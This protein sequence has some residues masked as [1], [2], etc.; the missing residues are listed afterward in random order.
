MTALRLASLADGEA[1]DEFEPLVMVL[2]SCFYRSRERR[3]LH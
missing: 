2:P 1:R 3:N